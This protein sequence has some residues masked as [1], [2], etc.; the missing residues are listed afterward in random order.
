MA[1]TT[2]AIGLGSTIELAAAGVSPTWATLG[3]V[4]NINGPQEA[5]QLLETTHML[6]T[7]K[8]FIPGVPDGGSITVEANYAADHATHNASTGVLYFER[9]R[10]ACQ[11]RITPVGATNATSREV[12][13]VWVE[14][15]DRSFPVDGVQKLSVTFK[16]TG[17]PV[18]G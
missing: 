10:L 14:K 9:N 16:L 7:Q 6:S 8:E 2:P 1:A 3:F 5:V 17:S 18:V 13:Q 12:W 11:I 4:T 15:V